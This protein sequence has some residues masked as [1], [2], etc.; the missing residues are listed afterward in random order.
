MLQQLKHQREGMFLSS[1]DD[2]RKYLQNP[3][4]VRKLI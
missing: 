4:I 1:F 2:K 3:A